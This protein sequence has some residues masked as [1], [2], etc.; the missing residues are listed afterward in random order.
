MRARRLVP[1]LAWTA[2]IAWFSTASWSASN[3]GRLLLPLLS[4]ILPW[5]SPELVEALHWLAR[6]TGHVVEYAILAA[7]WQRALGGWPWPLGLSVL[8]AGLDE[9]HQAGSA[10]RGG[11]AADVLLDS[12]AA[13]TALLVRTRGVA[14]AAGRATG[15]LLWVA[16]IGGTAFL[17]LDW[18]VG[19]PAGW[20]PVAAP[21]AWVALLLRR[22]PWRRARAP[23]P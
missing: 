10:A 23:R 22:R 16:A 3:T 20:L 13:G 12:A 1:P 21:A 11:S 19:A 8:T 4:W 6:K 5:A 9:W 17:A 2:V 7:L 18:I 15:F 14:Q